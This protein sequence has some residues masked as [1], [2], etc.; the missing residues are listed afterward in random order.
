MQLHLHSKQPRRGLLSPRQHRL[1]GQ[2]HSR[3][4][5]MLWPKIPAVRS[6]PSQCSK[7]ERA[8]RSR[9][10]APQCQR[11]L[12]DSRAQPTMASPR[13]TPVHQ[14]RIRTFRPTATQERQTG[15]MLLLNKTMRI[16][17]ERTRTIIQTRR[18]GM[19]HARPTAVPLQTMDSLQT[20]PGLT[21]QETNRQ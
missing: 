18:T 2:Y 21:I 11:G 1:H 7:S 12:P 16:A 8:Y 4:G 3:P 10:R 20:I 6:I 5:R 17:T 19:S 15:R 14:L 9:R 13:G